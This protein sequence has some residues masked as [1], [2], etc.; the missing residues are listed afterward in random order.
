MSMSQAIR[1]RGKE[2]RIWREDI[3]Q[4]SGVFLT[5]GHY[6][7]LGMG[8]AGGLA[9]LLAMIGEAMTTPAMPWVFGGVRI[10]PLSRGRD[11]GL[12]RWHIN[13]LE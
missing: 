2:A 9:L 8:K 12:Q 5:A 10:S 7:F 13:E 6:F 3:P 11:I 4:K 1:F